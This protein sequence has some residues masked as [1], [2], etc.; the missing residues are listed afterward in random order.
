MRP[1]A[2]HSC[3]LDEKARPPA[4]TAVPSTS[5]PASCPARSSL[6]R[7]CRYDGAQCPCSSDLFPRGFRMSSP[8]FT[9]PGRRQKPPLRGFPRPGRPGPDDGGLVGGRR[10][11][12]HPIPRQHPPRR[13]RAIRE[14]WRHCLPA[15][16]ITVSLTHP[17]L[18]MMVRA[19]CI[20]T[21]TW[22]A[23]TAHPPIATNAFAQ[24]HLAADISASRGS[25]L[26]TWTTRNS[27]DSPPHI[28]HILRPHH[29]PS[30]PGYAG[31]T[32]AAQ[33]AQTIWPPALQGGLLAS[34]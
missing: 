22:K 29:R 24:A 17:V 8:I 26:P 28:I 23:T 33:Y 15:V 21:C 25:P 31:S 30:A 4:P 2:R 19:R 32:V 14:S 6:T 5:S 7:C 27:H 34:G 9:S 1:V 11:Y 10:G 18:D 3:V 13:D 20:S 12:L 16:R